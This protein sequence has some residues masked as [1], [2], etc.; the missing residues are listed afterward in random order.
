[1]RKVVLASV[2][3]AQVKTKFK[4]YQTM[5]IL[6]SSHKCNLVPVSKSPRRQG[7][8][9]INKQEQKVAFVLATASWRLCHAP[10]HA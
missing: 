2:L 8:L 10:F 5:R 3:L 1:M 7:I 4:N 9:P 6:D